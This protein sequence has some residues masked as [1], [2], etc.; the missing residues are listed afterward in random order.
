MNKKQYCAKKRKIC[1]YIVLFY[2]FFVRKITLVFMKLE[3]SDLY[4]RTQDTNGYAGKTC[5][6]LE[7]IIL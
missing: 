3:H 7:F 5:A 1:Q 4:R 6:E 2:V